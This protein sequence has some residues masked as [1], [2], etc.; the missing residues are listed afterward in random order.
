MSRGR[1]Q[2]FPGAFNLGGLMRSFFRLGAL[3][4]INRP[5][6][7]L[8]QLLET[9]FPQGA[10]K[11]EG[12]R[13]PGERFRYTTQIFLHAHSS[14]ESAPSGRCLPGGFATGPRLGS[15]GIK[16]PPRARR[17]NPK[18]CPDSTGVAGTP[19]RPGAALPGWRRRKPPTGP[20][21][22]GVESGLPGPERPQPA[23]R[24]WGLSFDGFPRHNR[25][26]AS[27]LSPFKGGVCGKIMIKRGP[28]FLALIPFAPGRLR[29]GGNGN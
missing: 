20:V 17:L 6:Y 22:A 29:A 23:P 2:V 26:Q 11:T 28:Q 13:M 18:N 5:V 14:K 7:R 10:S 3:R 4:K 19:A 1:G 12:R 16:R 15:P 25:Y 27:L 24:S 21:P 8:C 9:L